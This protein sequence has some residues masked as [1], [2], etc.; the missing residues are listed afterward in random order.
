MILGG[1]AGS[2][3]LAAVIIWAMGQMG[4]RGVPLVEPDPRPFRVRPDSTGTPAPP[5]Q[6]TILDRNARPERPGEQRLAP[7]PEQPRPEGIRAQSAAQNAAQARPAAPP[8]A[9]PAA[10]PSAQ[11]RQAQP[12]PATATQA[13]PA[14]QAA[15]AQGRVSIQ[16]GALR[17]EE[18]A[19]Q[20]WD[21]LRA[22]V[23]ELAGRTPAITRF[24]REGQPTLWRLRVGGLAD[25]DAARALCGQVQARGG[26]CNVV[27]G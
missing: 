1:L 2:A 6:A 22:R 23:P 24:E 26:A 12:A 27:G 21:R 9:A 3:A 11:P 5:P 14:R 17:S 19:R 25:R 20:E 10:T 16:L 4:P 8:A 18:A 7:G 15:A 13:A